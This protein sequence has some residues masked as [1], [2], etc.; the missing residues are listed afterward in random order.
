MNTSLIVL[1]DCR[2]R[3]SV[4]CKRSG[5]IFSVLGAVQSM[6]DRQNF[7]KEMHMLK[8]ELFMELIEQGK[9]PLRPGVTRIISESSSVSSQALNCNCV[10]HGHCMLSYSTCINRDRRNK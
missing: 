4:A 6:E 3:C 9:L 10:A 2:S 5:V 7:V 1:V 8:T